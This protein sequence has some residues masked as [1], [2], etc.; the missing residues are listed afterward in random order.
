MRLQFP[1]SQERIQALGFS[2][3]WQLPILCKLKEQGD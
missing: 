3:L 1:E 2:V